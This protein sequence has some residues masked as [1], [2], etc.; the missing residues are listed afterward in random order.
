[1]EFDKKDLNSQNIIIRERLE[2][3]EREANVMTQEVER[4]ESELRR[5]RQDGESNK[6][7]LLNQIDRLKFKVE[8]TDRCG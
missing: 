6:D 5:I 4:L 1:L 7:D 8:E 3:K 2:E